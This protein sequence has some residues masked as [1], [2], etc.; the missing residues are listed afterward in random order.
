MQEPI[1]SRLD[2]APENG[3][4][5][6]FDRSRAMHTLEGVLAPH[7][8]P[9]MA[10]ASVRAHSQHLG[11]VEATVLRSEQIEDLIHRLGLGLAVLVGRERAREVTESMRRSLE[12]E[13]AA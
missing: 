4:E 13:E 9:H 7:I 2:D 5:A 10:R 8:G 6:R 11:I 1:D 3:G 12:P